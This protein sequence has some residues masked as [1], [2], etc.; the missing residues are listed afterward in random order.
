MA[1]LPHRLPTKLAAAAL[2]FVAVLLALRGLDASGGGGTFDQGGTA[3][4]AAVLPGASTEDRIDAVR[5]RLAAA[6]GDAASLATLGALLLQKSRDDADPSYYPRA[7]RALRQALRID[8]RSFDATTELGALALAR[9]DFAAG[10]S[11]GQRARR[12]NPT[13]ARNYG[14]IADAQI[15][16][17]HYRDA[18]TTLQRWVNLEPD[19]SSYAR[20]SYFRELHGD[21]AGALAAMRLAVSAASG[22]SAELTFAKNLVGHL[23]FTG[24]DYPGARIAYREALAASPGD[25]TALAGLG[26]LAAARGQYAT[27]LRHYRSAQAA[28]PTAGPPLAIGEIQELLGRRAAAERSYAE[29]RR[30]T[31]AEIPFG[32]DVDSDLAL[33]EAEH[34]DPSIAL[35][36]ARRAWQGRR[37]VITADALA[38]S[39]HAAG[40]DGQALRISRLAMRLG[41]RDPL[42]LY[43]AGTIAAEAGEPERARALLGRLLD[44]SPRFN[45]LLAPRARQTLNGLG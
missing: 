45:P 34:G 42:F 9:H 22:E 40:R 17:G 14:V 25:A 31:A 11:F 6:P 23:L 3:S 16:L 36:L 19:L 4:G 18:Q 8:P 43:R 33:L 24:G 27:A 28:T 35:S 38:W 7:E 12:I 37:S 32:V 26:G 10:L 2:G 39:L 29:A 41:S 13:I 5:A 20:V 44:Q 15:E 1:L 21:L 30:L